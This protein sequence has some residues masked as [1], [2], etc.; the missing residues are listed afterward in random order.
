MNAEDAEEAA[1]LKA[2]AIEADA[3]VAHQRWARQVKGR[4]HCFGIGKIVAI[5]LFEF[6]EPI[7]GS[8]DRRLWIVVGDLPSAYLVVNEEDS[9]AQALESYCDVMESWCEAVET[10]GSLKDV[11]PVAAAPTKG[12]ASLLRKRIEFIRTEV[13]K[14]VPETYPN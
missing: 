10:G 14:D 11:F 5:F 2:M 9:P 1:L 6:V 12:N 7:A 8:N 13:L 4:T 3:Y